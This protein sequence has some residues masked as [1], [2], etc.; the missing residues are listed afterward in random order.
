MLGK[1]KCEQQERVSDCYRESD[2][3][4]RVHWCMVTIML[5]GGVSVCELHRQVSDSLL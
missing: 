3:E 2:C 5:H 4:P 1:V